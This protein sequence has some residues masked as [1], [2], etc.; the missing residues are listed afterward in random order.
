MLFSLSAPLSVLFFYF[1]YLLFKKKL[2]RECL[3]VS[4]I[5]VVL[6]VVT[7]GFVVLGYLLST[8]PV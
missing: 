4:G 5:A 1:T 3:W 8:R 6:L 2:Y 7:L